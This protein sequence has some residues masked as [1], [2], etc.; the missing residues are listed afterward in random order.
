MS[1]NDE[2]D[3]GQLKLEQVLTMEYTRRDLGVRQVVASTVQPK[4]TSE[5]LKLLQ[6]PSYQFQELAH[7]KRVRKQ[8]DGAL[9]MLLFPKGHK[10]ESALYSSFF[11]EPNNG[12]EESSSTSSI[13]S[14]N[15]ATTKPNSSSSVFWR[16][17]LKPLIVEVPREQP[18]TRE[19][20][21]E[22][23]T[24]WP[25]SIP[26]LPQFIDGDVRCFKQSDIEKMQ[27]FMRLALEQARKGR[28]AGFAFSVGAVV[29]DP[30]K[31]E[32]VASGFDRRCR[33]S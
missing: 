23:T 22:W 2:K 18:L 16:F 6:Q 31:N 26:R 17:G 9:L 15:I 30:K 27:E 12:A 14:D 4:Q 33:S 19:Q 3:E 13:A 7:L 5:L 28:E 20:F 8:Q 11:G 29:V 32:V 25:F 1:S 10:R 24:L 21:D